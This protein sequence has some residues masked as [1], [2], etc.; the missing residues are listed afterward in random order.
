MTDFYILK[1]YF[2][3]ITFK[4][5]RDKKTTLLPYRSVYEDRKK[6]SQNPP[7]YDF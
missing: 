5:M 7:I 3:F 6:M 2:F 4:Q 1:L